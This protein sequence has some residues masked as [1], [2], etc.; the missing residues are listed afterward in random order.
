MTAPAAAA[1]PGPFD[2]LL[3][4]AM[5]A[6]RIT[7]LVDV[8]DRR[9]VVMPDETGALVEGT[10]LVAEATHDLIA[11]GWAQFGEVAES[12]PWCGGTARGHRVLPTPA[13][14]VLL[15]QH[16]L[17]RFAEPVPTSPRDP[18]MTRPRT[19]TV[20]ARNP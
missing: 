13:G 11:A 8:L 3:L 6:R 16:P 17:A 14:L 7:A 1:A 15:D 12:V 10:R 2:L 19:C 5:R 9:H 20:A 18:R 4:H